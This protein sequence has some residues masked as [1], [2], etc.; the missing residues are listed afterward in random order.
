MPT[1]NYKCSNCGFQFEITQSMKENPL[2]VCPECS[3]NTLDRLIFPSE[4]ILKGKGWFKDGYSNS[5]K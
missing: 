3:K 2:E 1:Y 4:F 5:S